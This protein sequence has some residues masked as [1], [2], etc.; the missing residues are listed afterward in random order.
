[1]RSRIIQS[2]FMAILLAF[3]PAALAEGENASFNAAYKAYQE[4]VEAKDTEAAASAAEEALN[5][6]LVVYPDDRA[7]LAELYV[8]AGKAFLKKKDHSKAAEFLREG[9]DRLELEYGFRSKQLIAPMNMLAH[10]VELGFRNFRYNAHIREEILG[11]THRH[12]G[13][14]SLQYANASML[15]G[16]ALYFLTD[17]SYRSARS[18]KYFRIA[19]EKYGL[20]FDKPDA[21][22]GLAAFWRGKSAEKRGSSSGAEKRY[23]EALEIFEQASTDGADEELMAHTYLIKL[24]EDRGKSDEAT[25]HCQAISHLRPLVGVDGAKPLYKKQLVYPRSAELAKRS[26]YVLMNFTVTTF[27]TVT[28]ATIVK[29]EGGKKGEFERAA[30]DAVTNYR[31]A[32]AVQ[33]GELIETPDVRGLFIFE[34]E[35]Y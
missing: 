1:M 22:T 25:L 9:I 31:Y 4:A 18:A 30:L 8:E 20:L 28:N 7:Q 29:S 12:Y 15:L 34:S 24:Y 35:D 17:G 19:F 26:G 32:P 2:I 27:G 23:L 33:D 6:A 3:A 16:Q 5:I 13:K 11:L 10:A 14:D 21:R